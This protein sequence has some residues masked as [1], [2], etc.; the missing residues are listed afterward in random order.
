MLARSAQPVRG[1]EFG[2]ASGK[3][4]AWWHD[5]LPGLAG[6]DGFDT[7]EGLPEPWTRGGVTVMEQGVFAPGRNDPEFPVI[8]ATTPIEWHKGLISDTIADLA[9][10]P[11]ERLLILVDV[12]LLEPT[13]DILDWVLVHGRPGD[14]IY[15]DEAFDPFNEGLALQ[16]AMDK[17]LRFRTL[18]FTGSALAVALDERAPGSGDAP[19]SG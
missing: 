7:F 17:G 14:I 15:F 1:L 13:R 16:E 18:G 12:D 3:A 6:W 4:T 9:R 10:D 5:H 2:V 11:G 8:D 19:E